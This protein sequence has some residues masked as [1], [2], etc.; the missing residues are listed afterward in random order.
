M[1][2][3]NS[4]FHQVLQVLPWYRFDRL[5]DHHASDARVRRLTS[6]SQLI[7]LL[8]AQLSGAQSLRDIEQSLSSHSGRLYH[9]G[10]SVPARSTLADANAKRPAQLFADLFAV[11]TAQ[12]SPGLRRATR[13]AI[14]LVDATSIRVTEIS[15][16]WADY[17]AH[18]ALVK[19]HVD[20]DADCGIA[21]NFAITP[22]RERRQH[23]PHVASRARR[24]L[25]L[26]PWIL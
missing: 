20:F 8:Y 18:G 3:H 10:A 17:A 23:G 25:C 6:K 4:L 9:L 21:A 14:H 22:A 1:R 19:L 12:A 24:H 16:A 13:E 15:R 11:L 7:A 2:H 26:R 5:V